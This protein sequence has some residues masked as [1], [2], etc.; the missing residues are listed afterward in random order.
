LVELVKKI[1]HRQGI[2]NLLADGSKRA[3]R[4]IGKGAEELSMTVKG[5]EMSGWDPRGAIGMALAYGTANRGGCHTTAAI[6]S[7]EIPKPEI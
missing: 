6:F 3:A 1:A 7:L 2:G 5:M 4:Q